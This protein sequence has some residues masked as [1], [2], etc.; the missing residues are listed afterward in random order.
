MVKRNL[1]SKYYIPFTKSVFI[2]IHIWK[3]GAVVRREILIFES[4]LFSKYHARS[5]PVCRAEAGNYSPPAMIIRFVASRSISLFFVQYHFATSSGAFP[6]DRSA[7]RLS[8]K[9]FTIAEKRLHFSRR[10]RVGLSMQMKYPLGRKARLV[11][12][13]ISW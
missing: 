7:L 12:T 6:F 2:C 3:A 9:Q 8:D 10:I 11:T 5:L 4:A 13:F 1:S